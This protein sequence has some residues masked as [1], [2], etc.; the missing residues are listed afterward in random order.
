MKRQDCFVKAI[1]TAALFA[2]VAV[3]RAQQAQEAPAQEAP[4]QEQAATSECNPVI[5]G[6]VGGILG[7][8]IGGDKRRT[9]SAAVGAAIGALACMAI[10]S[11]TKQTK[12]AQEVEKQV[13]ATRGELPAAPSVLSYRTIINPNTP[14]RP[15]A[16]ISVASEMEVVGGTQSAPSELKEEIILMDP[17]G[18]EFRRGSKPIVRPGD[19]VAGGFQNV[20]NFAMPSSAP[21]G[22][23]SV[24]TLLYLNGNV[25]RTADQRFQIV[26]VGESLPL[27][28]AQLQ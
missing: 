17:S 3:P 28:V 12:S 2:Y 18:K 27:N 7:A 21:Q 11:I 16:S 13:V 25:A 14:I 4:A 22:V 5:T 1:L 26:Q 23:Y 10:N 8:L 6:V 9:Q 19:S 24:R 15:G 20:F